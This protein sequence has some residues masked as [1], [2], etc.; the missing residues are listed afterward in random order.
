MPVATIW[1]AAPRMSLSV[2][3]SAKKFQLFQPIGGVSATAFG[4][5]G[6]LAEVCATVVNDE[7]AR[8]ATE[9]KA[10]TRMIQS[11]METISVEILCPP[12]TFSNRTP[13]LALVL[14]LISFKELPLSF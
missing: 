14:S 3:F 11:S 2:T 4:A 5:A 8:T 1:S 13:L 12:T 10:E 7:S 9:S 6:L